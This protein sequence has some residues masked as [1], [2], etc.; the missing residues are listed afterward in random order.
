VS[1]NAISAILRE[2]TARLRCG[3]ASPFATDEKA[4]SRLR[5][6]RFILDNH[7]SRPMRFFC[8][9]SK[10]WTFERLL[11][12]ERRDARLVAVEHH[13]GKFRISGAHLPGL[14]AVARWMKVA[15]AT[16]PYF[17]NDRA[18]LY[19]ANVGQFALLALAYP[20]TKWHTSALGLT[21]AWFDLCGPVSGEAAMMM[22][23]LPEAL[24]L[25]EPVPIV[26]TLHNAREMPNVPLAERSAN[27]RVEAAF[28]AF[29]RL[30]EVRR[31]VVF[32][33]TY[34]QML[35]AGVVIEK[36]GVE[37]TP[38]DI[39]RV[40]A[41]E[42]PKPRERA[43]HRQTPNPAE[44][45]DEKET[46]TE[47]ERVNEA[48][49]TA[50]RERVVRDETPGQLERAKE[51]ETPEW[52]ER[53]G[54]VK[55]SITRERVELNET[56]KPLERVFYRE[57]PTDDKRARELETPISLERVGLR[58]TPMPDERVEGRETPNYAERV[59]G[60]ET[61]GARERAVCVEQPNDSER[62]DTPET[63]EGR[64]RVGPLETPTYY[65]RP[66][67]G[68]RNQE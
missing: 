36:V 34:R 14:P 16:I 32:V 19:R 10:E 40:A 57:A 37:E 45:A 58:E 5:V 62:V 3:G 61:P 12:A 28:K 11:L 66:I 18:V 4:E 30:H 64:E 50:A 60:L 42:T 55:T 56:P 7:S 48:D 35:F 26:L 52:I 46:P 2:E 1:L 33:E 25:R 13:E 9:P 21:A 17:E 44:R 8:L 53:V 54:S 27:A 47:N 68:R 23:A 24:D 39:E 65:E 41:E 49:T 20:A 22:G 29:D 38:G 59:G 63:P 67:T 15:G 51:E 31:R 6:L 43:V